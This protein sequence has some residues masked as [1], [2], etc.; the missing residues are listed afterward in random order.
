[1]LTSRAGAHDNLPKI[2]IVLTDGKSSDTEATKVNR[3]SL[4]A[5]V[6]PDV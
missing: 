3:Q 2:V 5:I 6:A 4:L 1:M